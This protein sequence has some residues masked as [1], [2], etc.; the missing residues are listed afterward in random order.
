MFKRNAEI[1][2]CLM[3]ALLAG[4]V[5]PP[6]GAAEY[7]SKAIRVVTGYAAGGPND[8]VARALAQK[9]TERWGQ[10]AIVENRPGADGVIGAD[11]VAKSPA[12]GYMLLLAS[13]AHAI[14]NPQTVQLPFDPVK[15]FAPASQVASGP[16]IL[17]IH[18]SVP[19]QTAAQLIALAKGRPD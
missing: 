1:S 12:D 9:F 16:I 17:V 3:V 14:K 5:C 4:I 11:F 2:A 7:P 6:A 15:S 8:I 13:P 10:P 18:P 19:A